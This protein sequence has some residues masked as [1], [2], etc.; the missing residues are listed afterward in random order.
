L[1]ITRN[2][3]AIGSLPWIVE[4]K[5]GTRQY[6][7]VDEDEPLQAIL[8][9][10]NPWWSQQHLKELIVT[11]LFLAGNSLVSKIRVNVDG[12]DV[13]VELFTVRPQNIRPVPIKGGFI[14][15]YEVGGADGK[16]YTILPEDVVHIQFPDPA[17]PYWGLSPL[18]S[19]AKSIDTDV[20]AAGWQ[21]TSLQ[22]M[23]VPP[24]AFLIRG[25]INKEQ[26]KL[27]KK[28]LLEEYQGK[29][30]AGKPLILGGQGTNEVEWKPM[31]MTPA[32]VSF[33]ETRKLSRE[34]ICAI[35]GVP[36]PI[37]GLL[38]RA[39]YQNI[40]TAREIWW[41]DTLL[42][43]VNVV[44]SAFNRA[45]A[46]EYGDD[47]RV[48]SDTSKVDALLALFERRL[49]VVESHETGGPVQRCQRIHGSWIHLP[50]WRYW[51]SPWEH[52]AC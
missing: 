3:R 19:A 13:P 25:H 41:E 27:A 48:R 11:E 15:E 46:P 45:L 32:E 10:P 21:K 1:G 26:H 49:S 52:D 39:T 42:P 2:A 43:T 35:I 17:C 9:N 28:I 20:D 5:V 34:E 12:E 47:L 31:G 37:V 40:R 6:E 7:P 36:P 24:G 18:Q 51:L 14:K 33:I 30:N 16:E 38:E 22:N 44:D 29:L 50:W 4:R 23:L 8:D